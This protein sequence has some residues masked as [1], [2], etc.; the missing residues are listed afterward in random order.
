MFVRFKRYFHTLQDVLITDTLY[1][2][3]CM[4]RWLYHR[5][6]KRDITAYPLKNSTGH[7]AT[8]FQHGEWRRERK[9]NTPILIMH[10]V[11]SHPIVMLHLAKMAQETHIGPIFTLDVSYDESNF[12]PHRSLIKQALDLI[13]TLSL[14]KEGCSEGIILVGHSM[15]AIEA[16]Y[17]AFVMKDTRIKA[18]IS[19]AGRLKLI[20]TASNPCR[21]SL[22]PTLYEIDE[23]VIA[24]P[25]IPL[26]QIVGGRDWNAPIESMVIR[27]EEGYYH[28]VENAMHFNILFYKDVHDK[29]TEFLHCASMRKNPKL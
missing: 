17:R 20:E 11:F 5:Y 18:I 6:I 9:S 26:Y 4:M 23:C 28:I 27:K 2:V 13:E 19:I 7:K 24:Q 22:K 14:E 10:G 12:D 3:P 21:A 1:L 16:V 29:F 8:L 25:D 15:G